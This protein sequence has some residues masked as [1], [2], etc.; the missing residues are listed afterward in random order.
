[1]IIIPGAPALSAF[2][3]RKLLVSLKQAVPTI[4]NVKA[5]YLHFADISQ[6]L[7]NKETDTLK[8]LM[9]YG[10]MEQAVSAS[11][12]LLLVAPRPGTISPWSSKAT[13]IAHNCGLQDVQRIERGTAYYIDSSEPFS[14][15]QLNEVSSLLH[16]R[17][18]ETVF[19]DL[20]Q[21]QTLF[22]QHQPAPL[23]SVDIMGG[24]VGAL[25]EANVS[26]GL[27]LADD[28]IDY[29]V[30][31]FEGLERNPTDAELMM[32]AQANSE[33]CRHK[34]F[35]AGWTLTAKISLIACLG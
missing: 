15:Q 1:M 32:F 2:R 33:H 19:Y 18:V 4:T 28:E 20:Q 26:L 9:Q 17:M 25:R 24:G 35:N 16:D 31:S 7:S 14:E 11:G 12:Q 29:L 3:Q 27:A 21:A 5:E 30:A 34:I 6:P 13:D 8:A 22:E 10:P 23:T